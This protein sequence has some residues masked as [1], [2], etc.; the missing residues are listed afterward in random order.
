MKISAKIHTEALT[1]GNNNS[2]SADSQ[3][4]ISQT[5]LVLLT[6]AS[7]EMT[8]KQHEKHCAGACIISWVA[9]L[10]EL[11]QHVCDILGSFR[12]IGAA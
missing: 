10:M 1:R 8:T 9:Y 3:F 7:E 5:L 6:T 11:A 2:Q 4:P 12:D